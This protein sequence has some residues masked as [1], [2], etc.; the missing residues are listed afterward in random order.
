MHE[1]IVRDKNSLGFEV[2]SGACD[3]HVHVFEPGR[4]PY[5]AS[6][7]YTPG[8]ASVDDLLALQRTLG[9]T[10]IVLVQPSV[11]GVDHACMLDALR[12]L[13]TRAKGVG[14]IDEAMAPSAILELDRAGIRGASIN[15]EVARQRD[16]ADA[17]RRLRKVADRIPPHWH[18]QIYTALPVIAALKEEIAGLPMP[19][20][21]DHFGLARAEGGPGQPGFE[22]LLTLVSS[23]R[24]YVKLSA[25][26]LISKRS[27]NYDDVAG[28]ARALVKACP[29]RVLWGSNWPHTGGANRRP[30]QDP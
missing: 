30:D 22:D 27:P 13:G 5:S 4:F 25:P 17:A 6:R 24:T 23:G 19:A 20:V 11:Y 29:D 8:Q 18:M 14:V 2:P 10:R 1:A 28:V 21:I 7:R 16:P 9:L 3:C 26:Y 12:R 15:L